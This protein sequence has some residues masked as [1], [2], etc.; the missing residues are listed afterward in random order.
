MS[1]VFAASGAGVTEGFSGLALGSTSIGNFSFISS[2]S[3]TN[4]GEASF[5][6]LG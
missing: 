4:L 3:L 2:S 5:F 6:F 1:S